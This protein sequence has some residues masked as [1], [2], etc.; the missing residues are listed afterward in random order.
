MF[1]C[2]CFKW[3]N[4]PVVVAYLVLNSRWQCVHSAF[5]S[6][7]SW[8]CSQTELLFTFFLC[9]ISSALLPATTTLLSLSLDICFKDFQ[10]LLDSHRVWNIRLNLP[11]FSA[12]LLNSVHNVQV[13]S[14]QSHVCLHQ[15]TRFLESVFPITS[16]KKL[17][18]VFTYFVGCYTALQSSSRNDSRVFEIFRNLDSISS[19]PSGS[20]YFRVL[21][22]PY[23][24]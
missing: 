23:Y 1:G 13:L 6:S 11:N 18:C 2:I 20:R 21:T 7:F 3:R 12:I 15:V 24:L 14:T 4:K 17:N 9:T 22:H 10:S 8:K 19:R 16:L 5:V